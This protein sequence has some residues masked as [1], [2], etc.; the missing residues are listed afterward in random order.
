M[1]LSIGKKG[2]RGALAAVI[3][4]RRTAFFFQQRFALV[5]SALSRPAV[6]LV[7]VILSAPLRCEMVASSDHLQITAGSAPAHDYEP[8]FV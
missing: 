5:R 7:G 6:S 3:N 1:H 4:R 2:G 8:G